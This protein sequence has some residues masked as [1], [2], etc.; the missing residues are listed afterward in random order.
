MLD[1][2]FGMPLP[3]VVVYLKV[4]MHSLANIDMS[5]K[6]ILIIFFNQF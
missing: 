3:K 6:W 1:F 4:P 5:V 2:L